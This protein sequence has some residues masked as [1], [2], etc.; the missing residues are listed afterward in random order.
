MITITHLK[1]QQ[2]GLTEFR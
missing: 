2:I 1:T